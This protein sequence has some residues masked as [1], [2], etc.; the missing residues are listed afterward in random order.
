MGII[1]SE[2]ASLITSDESLAKNKKEEEYMAYI[3]EHVDNVV[4]AFNKYFLSIIKENKELPESNY[5]TY[6][7]LYNAIEELEKGRIHEHDMSKYSEEEF[8]AYRAKY[9]PTEKE[10]NGATNEQKA[11]IDRKVDI[12]WIHHYE[13][14]PH[15][16]NYWVDKNSDKPKPT[17]MDLVS[18]LEMICDWEAMSMKFGGNTIDWY[19]NKADKEKVA[20]TD[21]TKNIVEELL[22]IIYKI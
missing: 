17:D 15:H 3:K 20:M 8:D 19:T 16:P 4:F 14:N 1:L 5:Y 13:N 12:A 9:Y 7:D 2:S 11:E 10:S 18:I 21:K 6:D 22:D